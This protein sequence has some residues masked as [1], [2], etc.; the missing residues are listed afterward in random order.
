VLMYGLAVHIA[1]FGVDLAA[2]VWRQQ[3]G[4][5]RSDTAIPAEIQRC[6]EEV[7]KRGLQE[8]G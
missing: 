7:E 4:N 1:V 8:Q 2:L 6:F 3:G 5:T